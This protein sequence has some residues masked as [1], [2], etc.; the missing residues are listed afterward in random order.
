MDLATP[1]NMKALEEAAKTFVT[2][3]KSQLDKIVELLIINK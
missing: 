3:N 1:A 2:D